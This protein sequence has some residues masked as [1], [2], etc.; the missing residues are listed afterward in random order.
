MKTNEMKAIAHVYASIKERYQPLLAENRSLCGPTAFPESK[1]E[2]SKDFILHLSSWIESMIQ[3]TGKI[4]D[5]AIAVQNR[6]N[7][8]W[9]KLYPKD[10]E[11]VQFEAL[12]LPQTGVV[13]SR[14]GGSDWLS[15][16][17]I[18]RFLY[19]SLG[20][21]AG[22]FHPA[23]IKVFEELALSNWSELTPGK[24]N[25]PQNELYGDARLEKL[26]AL[27]GEFTTEHDSLVKKLEHQRKLLNRITEAIA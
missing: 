27:V 22:N 10:R 9:R 8:S 4:T 16:S 14:R 2:V 20:Q 5:E 17:T 11:S 25:H 21:Y 1:A 23:T 7:Q 19:S 18:R 13:I 12:E 6:K 3:E 24:L 15:I 26:Q